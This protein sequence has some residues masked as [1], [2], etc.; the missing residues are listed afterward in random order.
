MRI[1]CDVRHC[2]ITNPLMVLREHIVI[3]DTKILELLQKYD[4]EHTYTV[5]QE[6]FSTALQVRRLLYLTKSG[7]EMATHSNC[8]KNTLATEEIPPLHNNNK[9][10]SEKQIRRNKSVSVTYTVN[11]CRCCRRWVCRWNATSLTTSP[12]GSPKMMTGKSTTGEK[13]PLS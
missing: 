10:H 3:T 5:T 6:E 13:R 12:N 11:V 9:H 1:L 4:T 2:Q 8:W 7:S